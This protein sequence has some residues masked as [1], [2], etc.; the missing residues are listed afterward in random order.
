[1]LSRS[2]EAIDPTDLNYKDKYKLKSVSADTDFLACLLIC[3]RLSLLP[4]SQKLGLKSL[5][6]QHEFQHEIYLPRKAP[7]EVIFRK[8]GLILGL[9]PANERRRYFVTASLIGWAQA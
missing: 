9:R 1:M 2:P 4:A 6:N 8:P 7:A 3:W 5:V